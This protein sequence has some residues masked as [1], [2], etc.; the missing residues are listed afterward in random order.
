MTINHIVSIDH[1]SCGVKHPWAQ[2]WEGNHGREKTSL[3]KKNKRNLS[4][5][6]S[7]KGVVFK[8]VQTFLRENHGEK[9]IKLCGKTIEHYF[10][11]NMFKGKMWRFPKWGYR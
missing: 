3:R 8:M 1:G 7:G 5:I 6:E 9:T 4:D 2:R 11:G 10:R